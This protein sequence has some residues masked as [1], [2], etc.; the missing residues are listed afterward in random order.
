MSDPT[1]NFVAGMAAGFTQSLAGH[2]FDT[3]KVLMQVQQ[4]E[5][6]S[7]FKTAR[8]LVQTNGARA[9]YRG[10]TAPLA[11]SL[12]FN[13]IMF[14]TY[15]EFKQMFTVNG[16]LGLMGRSSAAVLAGAC[17]AIV[18]CPTEYIKNRVQTATGYT[19]PWREIKLSV[20]QGGM[21]SLFKGLTPTLARECTGNIFYFGAYEYVKNN[22]NIPRPNATL[23]EQSIVAGGL[24]GTAY[25]V[26][27]LPIDTVKTLIQTDSQLNPRY[28]STLDCVRQ[29]L[30]QRGPLGFY[31]GFTPTVIRAFPANAV[32]F[33]TFEYVKEYMENK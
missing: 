19:N 6:K 5:K 24:A 1:V 17:E 16:E 27:M 18:Y 14:G 15:E 29:T 21:P 2:P 4:G 22:Y 25:W 33:L 32:L 23:A 7:L 30:A 13:S 9:L 3:C 8:D 26:L 20:R 12:V 31:N 11:S 10:V 28:K